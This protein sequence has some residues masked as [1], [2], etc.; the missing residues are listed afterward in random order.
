[1]RRSV[2]LPSSV[3]MR[4][5]T[6]PRVVSTQSPPTNPRRR[7]TPAAPPTVLPVAPGNRDSDRANPRLC[8][9]GYAVCD[10]EFP[11]RPRL[12]PTDRVVPATPATS[13]PG[14]R[15]TYDHEPAT[16]PTTIPRSCARHRQAVVVTGRCRRAL[17]TTAQQAQRA[18]LPPRPADNR[19]R[20]RRVLPVARS[21]PP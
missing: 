19:S 12:G 6:G 16:V 4:V 13:R 10:G 7:Q 11:A 2:S 9:Y 8:E 18:G 21:P 17:R 3:H 15:A 1:E 20:H 14:N 5:P